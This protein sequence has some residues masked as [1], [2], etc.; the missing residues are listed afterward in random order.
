MEYLHTAIQRKFDIPPGKVPSYSMRHQNL[1][2]FWF[3]DSFKKSHAVF[4]TY[5]YPE[6]ILTFHQER[7]FSLSYKCLNAR[8]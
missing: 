5:S 4:D 2:R 1:L 6:K 8:M 3:V 7:Y